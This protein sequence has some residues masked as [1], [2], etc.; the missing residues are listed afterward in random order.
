MT[1]VQTCAL[2]ICFDKGKAHDVIITPSASEVKAAV[3]PAQQ[4]L[5]KKWNKAK[6]LQFEKSKQKFAEARAK[7]IMAETLR[8]GGSKKVKRAS[9]ISKLGDVSYIRRSNPWETRSDMSDVP[10]INLGGSKKLGVLEEVKRPTGL[11]SIKRSADEMALQQH[12]ISE[13]GL[14]GFIRRGAA[15]AS[16]IGRASCRERV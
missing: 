11:E 12:R 16:E 6:R 5:I 8:R 14:K 10:R 3:R 2:P 15:S 7:K 9:F 4:A 13:K 1:G